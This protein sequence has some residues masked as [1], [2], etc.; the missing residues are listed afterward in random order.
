MN[1]NLKKQFAA[2]IIFESEQEVNNEENLKTFSFSFIQEYVKNSNFLEQKDATTALEKSKPYLVGFAIAS[3]N[4]RAQNAIELALLPLLK[5]SQIIEN[6]KSISLLVSSHT[7]EM[8]IDEIGI[9]NDYIQEKLEYTADIIMHV[10][11]EKNLGEAI[12]ITI[13]ISDAKILR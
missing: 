13:I 9:I 6:P 3:G 7:V 5:N 8:S 2:S 10:N 1:P 4:N 12:A 11:E